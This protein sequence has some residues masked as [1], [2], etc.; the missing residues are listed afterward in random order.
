MKE[1]RVSVDKFAHLKFIVNQ[2]QN[3]EAVMATEN[4][5]RTSIIYRLDL[6]Q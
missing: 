1:E 2:I 6:V 3:K 5:N 4:K